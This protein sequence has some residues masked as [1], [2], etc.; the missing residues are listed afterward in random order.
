MDIMK[1]ERLLKKL[2]RGEAT[3]QAQATAQPQAQ[4]ERQP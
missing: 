2:E 4:Q 1:V 3:P